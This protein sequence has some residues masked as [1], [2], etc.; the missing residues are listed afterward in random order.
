MAPERAG[1]DLAK[2]IHYPLPQYE[3]GIVRLVQPLVERGDVE[4]VG[5]EEIVRLIR[6]SVHAP[7]LNGNKG[8]R[9]SGS[10][11]C[12]TLGNRGNLVVSICFSG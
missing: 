6:A 4:I 2:V 8:E 12:D 11:G 1:F 9:R 7:S 5:I 10:T 3:V